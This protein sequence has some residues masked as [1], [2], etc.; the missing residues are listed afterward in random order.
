MSMKTFDDLDDCELIKCITCKFVNIKLS[1]QIFFLGEI[2]AGK[3]AAALLATSVFDVL[4]SF[5]ALRGAY[6][7]RK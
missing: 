6:K 5:L 1:W 4:I 3:V 2:K 7:V